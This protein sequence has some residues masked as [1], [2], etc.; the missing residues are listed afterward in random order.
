M[1][2]VLCARHDLDPS[3]IDHFFIT[4]ININSIR[5]TLDILNLPHERAHTIMDRFGYT[6]SA[7][8]PMAFDDAIQQ[9]RIK[10]GDLICF[11]GS[12]GGLSFASALFR[13]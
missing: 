12:G 1:I 10:S 6:G 11:I 9:G 5:E 2:K 4:Q 8:I 7:C 3:A 13:Y